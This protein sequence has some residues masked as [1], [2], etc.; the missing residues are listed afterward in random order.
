MQD[1]DKAIDT[2]FLD[3]NNRFHHII[4]NLNSGLHSF[5]HAGEEQF[6]VLEANDSV[7]LRLNTLD[8]DES[9]VFS[10]KGAK[11]KQLSN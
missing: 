4:E 6:M 10:G 3:E 5:Y 11:K 8:F 9:L 1:N 2:L 7:M